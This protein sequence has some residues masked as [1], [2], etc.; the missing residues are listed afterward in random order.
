MRSSTLAIGALT[1]AILS[2]G[3]SAQSS[4]QIYGIVDTALSSYR[5]E[6]AGSR[7][8][9]TPGGN[10]A[11][12]L[13]FRERE[14][15]GGGL[16]AGFD[17][18]AGLN[19]DTGTGQTTNTNN[20]PS[21]NA[22]GGGLTFNRRS[23]LYLQSQQWGEIRLGR[24]YTPAFW[25]LFAYDPFRAGVGMSAHVLH[26]TTVTAF[27]ASNSV[28][29]F[30]PGCSGPS[31]KGLFYQAML[32]FGENGAGPERQDGRVYG[33]RIGYGYT[34][35]E[36]VISAATTRNRAADDYAQYSIG[37][38]YLW[39]GHRF[40]ALLGENRTGKRQATLDGANQVRFWQLGA[41]WKVGTDTI[42]MSIMRLT[43]NDNSA[44][45]SQKYAIGYVH[46]LSK[47][48]AIYGTY[49]YVDNR[50]SINLP[51]ATGGLNGP[52]PTA[53]GNAS[54]FDLGIRHSF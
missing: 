2:G 36:A 47:R 26:G 33:M 41:I 49:A 8:L 3:A 46:N 27:R 20:Q 4:L 10:Q 54:G 39:E 14:D 1:C 15:L 18:E 48:T 19:T 31:C 7:Q 24:D 5:A 12:R 37:G 35:W 52:I 25:N 53:G 43:R 6:G 50:G 34:Q 22:G 30:S 17:L 32:A 44:S 23:Y 28:G 38:S 13:G 51:V 16:R 9:L 21:G 40:M 42:P 11:S 29:Y 45:S